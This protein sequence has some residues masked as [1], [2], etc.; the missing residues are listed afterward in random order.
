MSAEHARIHPT[1]VVDP[2]AELGHD[3]VIGPLAV[4]E[5]ETRLGDGC[6]LHAGAVVRRWTTLGNGNTVHSH[7]VLGGDPQDYGHD[8]KTRSFVQIGSGNVFR[9]GATVNRGTGEDK[10]TVIGDNNYFMT[11]AH[12]GHNCRVGSR[13]IMTNGSA[14]GGYVELNDRAILS[15]N[16]VIHQFCRVGAGVMSGGNS[17]C[18][19]H[20]PPWCMLIGMNTVTG[21]NRV[22]LRRAGA[23]SEDRAHIE[24]AFRIFFRSS[25]P[26]NQALIELRRRSD[27]GPWAGAFV[28]FIDQALHAEG[29]FNRGIMK[30]RPE[31][32]S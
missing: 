5:A 2:S 8:P 25:L 32:F 28:D 11:C 10:V 14:L 12:V 18:S 6:I 27:W 15:A 1:A 31:R 22:G 23:S 13:C 7:A 20:L 16:V 4:V 26:A 21:L 19:M 9:E 30:M 3:V 24:E 17:V 29:S